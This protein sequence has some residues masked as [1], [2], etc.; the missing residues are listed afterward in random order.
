M[1][2]APRMMKEFWPEAFKAALIERIREGEEGNW[3]DHKTFMNNARQ[4]I[5]S[6][7]AAK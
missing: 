6:A 5:A 4:I 3:V 7:R 2:L 1:P